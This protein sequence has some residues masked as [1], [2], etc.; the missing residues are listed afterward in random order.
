M[1]SCI[2]LPPSHS[3]VLS[4]SLH[5]YQHYTA[6]KKNEGLN[7]RDRDIIYLHLFSKLFAPGRIQVYIVERS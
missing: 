2:T 3:I 1:R 4:H 5:A 6:T 7:N